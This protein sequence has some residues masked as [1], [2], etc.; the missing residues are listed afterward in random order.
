MWMG[1]FSIHGD[2][3]MCG[4]GKFEGTGEEVVTAHF[5]AES[6]YTLLRLALT[7]QCKGK[8]SEGINL[9]GTQNVQITLMRSR[10]FDMTR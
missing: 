9:I 3:K 6:R 2:N 7:F 5:K 4:Y 10:V 8:K 1:L